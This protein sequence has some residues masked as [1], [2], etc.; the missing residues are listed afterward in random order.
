[1]FINDTLEGFGIKDL[2]HFDFSKV[3]LPEITNDNTSPDST[4]IIV[5]ATN[6]GK[7]IHTA[8]G[9]VIDTS[10]SA[11]DHTNDHTKDTSPTQEPDMDWD[12]NHADVYV[13]ITV[14]IV[15][16]TCLPQWGHLFG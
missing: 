16:Q 7:V 8:N 15:W 3:K 11:N 9:T 6:D 14:Y 10:D 4:G 13:P 2:G 1:M 5:H 12:V